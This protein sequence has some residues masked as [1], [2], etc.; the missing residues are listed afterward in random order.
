MGFWNILLVYKQ[1]S[2]NLPLNYVAENP[3]TCAAQCNG[4]AKRKVQNKQTK[5]NSKNKNKS[6]ADVPL[7]CNSCHFHPSVRLTFNITPLKNVLYF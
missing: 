6:Y 1:K 5:T 4:V 3:K 7:I 2:E